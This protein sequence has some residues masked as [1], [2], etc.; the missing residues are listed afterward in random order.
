MA[1]DSKEKEAANEK[2]RQIYFEAG[3]DYVVKDIRGIL[4]LVKE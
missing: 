1:L 2:A 3:A 4:D